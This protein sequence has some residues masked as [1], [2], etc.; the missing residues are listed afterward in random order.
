MPQLFDRFR[1]PLRQ[2]THDLAVNAPHV[3]CLTRAQTSPQQG[4]SNYLL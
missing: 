3:F 2:T 1:R 4:T